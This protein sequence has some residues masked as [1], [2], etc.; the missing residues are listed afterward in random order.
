[1]ILYLCTRHIVCSR[2][3]S[4]VYREKEMSVD[5]L[6]D[7]GNGHPDSRLDIS[8]FYFPYTIQGEPLTLIYI[9]TVGF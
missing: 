3:R 5:D 9:L 2:K 7:S 6:V 8:N 4:N 1:M